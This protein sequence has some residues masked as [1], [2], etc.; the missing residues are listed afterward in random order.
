MF[1][2]LSNL[3]LQMAWGYL[4]PIRARG[5]RKLLLNAC[6]ENGVGRSQGVHMTIEINT[7]ADAG[8]ALLVAHRAG[9]VTLTARSAQ[10]AGQLVA[11][12]RPLTPAPGD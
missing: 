4:L 7:P 1:A 12:D 9:E 5:W 10:F 3:L 2:S 11:A 6:D 8:F